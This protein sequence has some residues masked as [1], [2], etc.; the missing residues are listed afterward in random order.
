MFC[1]KCGKQIQDDAIFCR[2]CGVSQRNE[3]DINSP[4]VQKTSSGDYSTEALRV[5]FSNLL[6]LEMIIINLKIVLKN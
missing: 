6:N 1:Y 3:N 2:F 5:Y 4:I